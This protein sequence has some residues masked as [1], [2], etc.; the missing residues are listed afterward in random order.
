MTLH[1]LK[2]FFSTKFFVHYKGSKITTNSMGILFLLQLSKYQKNIGKILAKRL[3]TCKYLNFVVLQ[4]KCTYMYM[5]VHVSQPSR[6][7]YKGHL[8]NKDTF[9]GPSG[10]LFKEVS[11]VYIHAY[12]CIHMCLLIPCV[13][14]WLPKSHVHVHKLTSLWLVLLLAK[15]KCY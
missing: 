13:Y 8:S 15:L 6:T 4:T 7:P 12:T 3:A 11:T 14:P 1:I 9:L 5:Y 10:V 2:L